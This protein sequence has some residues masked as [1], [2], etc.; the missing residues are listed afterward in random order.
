MKKN[1]LP[2]IYNEN[3]LPNRVDKALEWLTNSRNGWKETCIETK[4]KLKRQTQ[5]NK[6]VKDSR[7][8]WKLKSI[9]LKLELT[10]SK[11]LNSM[12][13]NRINELESQIKSKSK[14][15]YELKKKQ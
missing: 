14:E 11:E 3:K 9:R 6:R 15:L 8:V 4:L 12:Y 1:I 5:E 13:Q 7:D 10:E 2:K